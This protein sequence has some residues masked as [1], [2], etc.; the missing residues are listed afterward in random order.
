MVE[1][2]AAQC[3]QLLLEWNT[4]TTLSFSPDPTTAK[5]TLLEQF[6]FLRHCLGTDRLDLYLEILSRNPHRGLLHENRWGS[7]VDPRFFKDPMR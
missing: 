3:Q 6:L 1:S 7:D 4:P 5:R 2:I